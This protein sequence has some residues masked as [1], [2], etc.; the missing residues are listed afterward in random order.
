MLLYAAGYVI[1][2][3]LFLDIPQ[4]LDVEIKVWE[5]EC[6]GIDYQ[7][8]HWEEPNPEFTCMIIEEVEKINKDWNVVIIDESKKRKP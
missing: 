3:L 2:T 7:V 4:N 8:Q 5:I 6:N 1:G